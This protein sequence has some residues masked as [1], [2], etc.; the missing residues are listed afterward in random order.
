MDNL[1]THNTLRVF[2]KHCKEKR[3]SFLLVKE[4]DEPQELTFLQAEAIY[5]AN[6]EEKSVPLTNTH[7]A[8]VEKALA[9]FKKQLETEKQSER[10]VVITQS[11]QEK[12]ASSYLDGVLNFAINQNLAD[13]NE[14][15]LLY[16]AKD[17]INLGKFAKLTKDI[18]ALA[19]NIKKIQMKATEQ[20]EAVLKI[21]K[22][23]PLQE[24]EEQQEEEKT[25]NNEKFTPEIIISESFTK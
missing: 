14:K 5:R 16:L 21:A 19:K 4:N 8:Q 2:S 10:A 1:H 23:Y 22:D 18:A 17:A 7:H 11:P 3:N 9:L 6:K 25:T 12:Q 20:L 13:E 24:N 15:T